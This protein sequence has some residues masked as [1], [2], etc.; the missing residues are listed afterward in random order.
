MLR[1]EC[2][3]G[4][5]LRVDEAQA[6]KK[7][8]CPACGEPL[9][10][11]S[12]PGGG[13]KGPLLL[14]LVLGGVF[15]LCGGLAAAGGAVW[16]IVLRDKPA[17]TAQ[18]TTPTDKS[19]TPT[20]DTEKPKDANAPKM[21]LHDPSVQWL[22]NP[23][24]VQVAVNW[25]AS[26]EPKAKSWFYCSVVIKNAAGVPV[27]YHVDEFPWY[28]VLNSKMRNSVS[29]TFVKVQSP[30]PGTKFTC[31][32]VLE[33]AAEQGGPRTV[34]DTL[35]NIP[36]GGKVPVYVPDDLRVELF[37][38]QV[39]LIRKNVVKVSVNYKFSSQP[40]PLKTYRCKIAFNGAPDGAA[41]EMA[42]GLGTTLAKEGVWTDPGTGPADG[43]DLRSVEIMVLE[44][45]SGEPHK[46]KK[47]ASLP[48]VP[49]SKGK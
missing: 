37:N 25:K 2:D 28:H 29:N 35:T 5:V 14:V 1:I 48:N 6:G 46:M 31:D 44:H 20:T 19:P 21:T 39:V 4:K 26:S 36:I 24:A 23:P 30:G 12:P 32:V 10:V 7:V 47:V 43:S 33:Y 8:K 41:L 22:G 40:D 38:P 34:L 18:G 45:P 42:S 15:V 9:P 11:P 13:K 27:K 3:C 49:I 16:F 17:T